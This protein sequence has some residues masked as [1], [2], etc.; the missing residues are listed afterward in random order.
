M[1]QL[2]LKQSWICSFPTSQ[3]EIIGYAS[4]FRLDRNWNEEGIIAFVRENI[5]VNSLF[6]EDRLIETFLLELS[7]IKSMVTMLFL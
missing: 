3:F 6:S 2:Y 1:F 4:P 7:F 5:Q